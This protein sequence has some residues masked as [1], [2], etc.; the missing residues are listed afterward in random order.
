MYFRK[1]VE[2]RS[3]QLVSSQVE[4]ARVGTGIRVI[5]NMSVGKTPVSLYHTYP[6]DPMREPSGVLRQRYL[7]LKYGTVSTELLL[8][9]KSVNVRSRR[10]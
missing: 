6:L 10:Y 5:V 1:S 8:K 2:K 3:T 7:R 4:R 9:V